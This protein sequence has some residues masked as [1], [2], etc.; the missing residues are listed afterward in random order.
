[1]AK[2]RLDPMLDAMPY[3]M[4]IQDISSYA[5]TLDESV[6]QSAQGAPIFKNALWV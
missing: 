3:R 2:P 6:R 4:A 5:G 1:M